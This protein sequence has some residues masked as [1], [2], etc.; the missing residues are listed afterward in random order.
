VDGAD[1]ASVAAAVIAFFAMVGSGVGW[2]LAR[3][4]KAEAVRQAEQALKAAK[5]A[6]GHAERSADAHERI[7]AIESARDAREAEQLE[8]D[9]LDPWEL[10][11]IPGSP[12]CWLH[13]GTDTPKYGV[14]VTGDYVHQSPLHFP[15]IGRDRRV[16]VGILRT[17]HPEGKAHVTWHR[18]EDLSDEPLPWSGDIPS[19]M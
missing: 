2:L 18:N 12:D 3:R 16:E 7:A 9:E 1:W 11:P 17:S 4:E 19:R 8:A 14:E 13:N 15:V 6:A 5:D 10:L